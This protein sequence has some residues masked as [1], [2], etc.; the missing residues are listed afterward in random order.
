MTR[1][2]L[3]ISLKAL[4]PQAERDAI[5]T[6]NSKPVYEAG[7][8]ALAAVSERRLRRAEASY[9]L[10]HSLQTGL[11]ASFA[12]PAQLILTLTR[13]G[14]LDDGLIISPRKMIVTGP[15]GRLYVNVEPIEYARRDESAERTVLFECIVPG[16]V[17]NL[18]FL[19]NDDI[20]VPKG[21]PAGYFREEHLSLVDQSRGRVNTGAS[22]VLSEGTTAIKDSG[23]PVTF[24]AGDRDLYAEI[25]FS[26]T[27]SQIGRRYRI[28]EHRWPGIE[29]PPGS[30]IRPTYA[31]LDD[32]NVPELLRAAVLDDGGVFTDYTAAANNQTAADVPLLP[33]VPVVDDAFY[34]GATTPINALAVLLST[35]A[36]AEYELAWEVWDGFAWTVPT[37]VNDGS[38][39]L[40]ST[41]SRRVLI[42]TPTLQVSTTVN[43]VDA[44]WVRVR[45]AAVTSVTTSPVASYVVPL[46]FQPLNIEDLTIEWAV[47]DWK[48]LGMTITAAKHYSL[49]RDDDLGLLGDN[50]G[51]YRQDGET[52]EAFR[53]R[54]SRIPD[55]VSPNAL[56]RVV[57]RVLAPLKM[58]GRVI[59]IGD[60]VDGFFLDQDALDYYDPGDLYPKS[61]WK[62]LLSIWE[63]YGFFYVEVPWLA[64]GDFGMFYDE[65]QTL[66]LQQNGLYIGPA[67]DDGFYDGYSK[68][69]AETYYKGIFE[70]IRRRK[71]GGVDFAIIPNADLNAP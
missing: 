21:L 34:F 60:K 51:M 23:I 50:R 54:I 12:R 70:E 20:N 53:A 63:A 8:S 28:R 26:A 66:L 36:D 67:Y 47:R 58:T 32:A 33:A 49:G 68:V 71:G 31:L 41:G 7:M 6:P 40:T 24:E 69:S 2:E 61:P 11:P 13:T 39:S 10:P 9:L 14:S 15:S 52:E 4:V 45:V 19:V 65:G 46:C 64:E 42:G 59:D 25:L 17:G 16:E 29:E 5:D 3:L 22:I 18:D 55:V 30:N 37:T 43:G 48:D 56:T 44:Y 62:L 1:D 38:I 57:N 35:A 27:A